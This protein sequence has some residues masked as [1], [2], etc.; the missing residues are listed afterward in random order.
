MITVDVRGLD[1]VRAALLGLERQLPYA[2]AT[3]INATAYQVMQIE[4]EQIKT[5]FDAPTPFVVRGMRYQKATKQTLTAVVYAAPEA[6]K[7][8]VANVEGGQ[9]ATKAYEGILRQAGVMSAGR[10]VV[11]GKGAKLDRYGN[12]DRDQL[13]AILNGLG[14]L[15]VQAAQGGSRKRKKA[16]AESGTYFV[17]GRGPAAHLRPGIWQRVGRRGL[18]PVLLFVSR[19]TYV[20]RYQFEQT[21]RAEV[22]RTFAAN[23]E[24]A[25]AKAVSTAR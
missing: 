12:L 25:W 23:F 14:L 6:A 22:V 19:A 11:P 4:R 13:G 2:T 24:K 5:V 3:A 20:E 16:M 15:S 9:R 21:A 18:R 1:A 7:A 17:G 8:L 10:Y